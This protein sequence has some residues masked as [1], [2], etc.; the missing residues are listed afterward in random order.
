M[1]NIKI[2]RDIS[3][4]KVT[5]ISFKHLSEYQVFREIN[6]YENKTSIVEIKVI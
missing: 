5:H 4:Q 1:N 2:D 3:S 6:D